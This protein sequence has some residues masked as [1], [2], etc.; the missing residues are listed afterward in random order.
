MTDPRFR[1]LP[2]EIDVFLAHASGD[3]PRARELVSA[4]QA[5]G[6]ST[7]IDEDLLAG[8]DWTLLLPEAL[9]RSMVVVVMV[10]ERYN[11]AHYLRDEVVVAI[12]RLRKDPGSRVV[13]PLLLGSADDLLAS[14]P[15]GLSVFNHLL[16]CDLGP[17]ETAKR[18]ALVARRMKASPAAPAAP[19]SPPGQTA[20]GASFTELRYLGEMQLEVTAPLFRRYTDGDEARM[21]GTVKSIKTA[22][23]TAPRARPWSPERERIVRL[24]VQRVWEYPDAG[25]L[26]RS[27]AV[28]ES[29]VIRGDFVRA[30]ERP[31]LGIALFT[32]EFATRWFGVAAAAEKVRNVVQWGLHRTNIDPPHLLA[33][34]TLDPVTDREVSVGDLRHTLALGILMQRAGLHEELQQQYA[35]MLSVHVCPSGGWSAT[36]HGPVGEVATTVYAV[37]FLGSLLQSRTPVVSSL[38]SDVTLV[39]AELLPLAQRWLCDAAKDGGWTI[40]VFPGAPWDSAWSTSYILM[41]LLS[42]APPPVDGWFHALHRIAGWLVREAASLRYSDPG[43][44]IRVEARI[45]A[46]LVAANECDLIPTELA[47][48]ADAWLL[49]WEDRFFQHARMMQGDEPDLATSTFAARSLLRGVHCLE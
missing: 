3:K 36:L 10:S 28:K 14:D 42:A 29:A 18:L 13:V 5:E 46:A 19:V 39:A 22:V 25:G 30:A 35:Q 32:T 17:V 44:R 48:R 33:E 6:L 12:A 41:R 1:W 34:T 16:W 27:W 38:R 47:G 45:A 7:F 24:L 21:Q 4:L 43:L 49:D 11:G 15:Y 2:A 23:S 40:G 37:E 31:G 20:T 26:R 9:H 8:D